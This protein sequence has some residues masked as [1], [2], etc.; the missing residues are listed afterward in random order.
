MKRFAF[1]ILSICLL[2]I[3]TLGGCSCTGDT[4]LEF[5]FGSDTHGIGRGRKEGYGQGH[6]IEV[7][8]KDGAY[9]VDCHEDEHGG[10]GFHRS[11]KRKVGLLTVSSEVTGVE[12]F[13][14]YH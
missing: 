10:E 12:E 4:L 11:G 5:E 1:I 8:C 2:S 7:A 13:R 3:F 9:Q 6:L 14:Q